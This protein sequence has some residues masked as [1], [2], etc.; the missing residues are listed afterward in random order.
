MEIFRVLSRFGGSAGL[1]VAVGLEGLGVFL[2]APVAHVCWG[3]AG[4]S[5]GGCGSLG[6]RVGAAGGGRANP[7]GPAVGGGGGV[8]I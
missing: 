3:T 1:L 8:P 5:V 7:N 2:E 6:G 4:G